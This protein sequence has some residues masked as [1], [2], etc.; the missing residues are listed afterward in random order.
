LAH[1][2]PGQ[3][4]QKTTVRRL[5][6]EIGA[7]C[8][9]SVVSVNPAASTALPTEEKTMF[10][11]CEVISTYTRA[12]AIEDGVLVDLMQDSMADVARQHYKHPIACTAAVWAIMQRAV[13]NERHGNDYAGI[14][15]DMLWMSRVYKRQ[16]DE[17]TVI[18]RVKI[19]GAGRRSLYDF[20]LTISPGDDF[21][22]VITITLP[23]E[24]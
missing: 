3:P 22:P 16:I 7:I 21:E 24:D 1:V 2:V 19:T 18:F 23:N 8:A 10:N 17:S 9:Y 11:A 13:E 6:V 12:E 4:G 15:H 5:V 14:L 20:K